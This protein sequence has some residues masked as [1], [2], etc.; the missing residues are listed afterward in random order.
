MKLNRIIM[1]Q[2]LRQHGLFV[3]LTKTDHWRTSSPPE[4]PGRFT[5]IAS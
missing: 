3:A 4:N 1:N 5:L 2:A